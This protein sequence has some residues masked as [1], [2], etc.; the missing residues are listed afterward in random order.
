MFKIINS[1]ILS[2]IHGGIGPDNIFS[3]T[4]SI[5]KLLQ[6]F[7]VLGNSP[8]KLLFAKTKAFNLTRVPMD[9][10]IFPDNLLLLKS[11]ISNDSTDFQQFGSSPVIRLLDKSK[12]IKFEVVLW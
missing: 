2:P 5:I 9:I 1:C 4:S 8:V 12:V 6:F 11:R 10:G 3:P 7:K